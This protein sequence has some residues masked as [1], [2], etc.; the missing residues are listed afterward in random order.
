MGAK[1]AGTSRKSLLLRLY[2]DGLHHVETNAVYRSHKGRWVNLA[3]KA[4]HKKKRMRPQNP[5]VNEN[6]LQELS[7][8]PNAGSLKSNS[9]APALRPSAST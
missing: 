5:N 3:D 6:G 1:Q 9:R 8:N 2:K 4:N 7:Q